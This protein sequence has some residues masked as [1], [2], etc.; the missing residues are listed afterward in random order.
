MSQREVQQ[1]V[2]EALYALKCQGLFDGF[3]DK[4]E[5]EVALEVLATLS[6]P[7]DRFYIQNI[8]ITKGESRDTFNVDLAV[9]VNESPHSPESTIQVKVCL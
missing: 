2:L 5:E 3:I 6:E 4:D 8:S 7:E 1:M 9:S